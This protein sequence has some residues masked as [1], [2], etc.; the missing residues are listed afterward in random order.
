MS[1]GRRNL[2]A[3]GFLAPNGAGFLI[4]TFIHLVVFIFI[5]INIRIISL[6]PVSV[7]YKQLHNPFLWS[8][9]VVSILT[10]FV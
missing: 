9:L 10:C 3:L 5:I 1:Q 7:D 4:F 8:C 2:A 6:L